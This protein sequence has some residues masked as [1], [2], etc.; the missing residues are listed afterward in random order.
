MR[1]A[2]KL[3]QEVR[4]EEL[5][6][7]TRVSIEDRLPAC[8]VAPAQHCEAAPVTGSNENQGSSR[9]ALATLF[10]PR[11]NATWTWLKDRAAR[12]VAENQSGR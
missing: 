6:G 1:A 4:T 2:L 9:L 12:R 8:N 7:V 3:L 11:Q 10:D 5:S